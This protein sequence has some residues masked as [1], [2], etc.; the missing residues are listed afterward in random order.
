MQVSLW[1]AQ[2]SCRLFP[3][4]CLK[5]SPTPCRFSWFH[6]ILLLLLRV[7]LT[8]AVTIGV[9]ALVRN[10]LNTKGERIVS[11]FALSPPACLLLP[12]CR[13]EEKK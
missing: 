6:N 4:H 2:P 1:K 8:Q 12:G 3:A 5:L 13:P 9:A 7:E 11:V 10:L